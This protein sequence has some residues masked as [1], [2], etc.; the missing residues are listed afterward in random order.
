MSEA[1][2][3]EIRKTAFEASAIAPLPTANAKRNRM[4]DEL[5]PTGVYARIDPFYRILQDAEIVQEHE[6]TDPDFQSKHWWWNHQK[7]RF[8][9]EKVGLKIILLALP[10]AWVL[11]LWFSVPVAISQVVAHWLYG[12][13]VSDFLYLL[14]Y[15][16]ALASALLGLF[17]RFG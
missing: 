4:G 12:S 8:L 16:G 15:L 17:S 14:A 11:F 9:N 13:S 3:F 5:Q 1:E 2:E 6:V 10:F 7:I